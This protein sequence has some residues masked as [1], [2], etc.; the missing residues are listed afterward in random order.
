MIETSRQCCSK[1]F[2]I[3]DENGNCYC[4]KYVDLYRNKNLIGV[5]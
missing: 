2:E 4:G 3:F 1:I 5:G